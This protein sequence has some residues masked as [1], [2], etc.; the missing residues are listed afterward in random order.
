MLFRNGLFQTYIVDYSITNS[1]NILFTT[2]PT[3]SDEVVLNYSVGNTVPYVYV[4][5]YTNT[6][7]TTST[8]A[9][10]P[11]PACSYTKGV[12]V[13]LNGLLRSANSDYTATSSG[14]NFAFNLS[15]SSVVSCFYTGVNDNEITEQSN[16]PQTVTSGRS[17]YTYF[18]DINHPNSTILSIDGVGQFPINNTYGLTSSSITVNDYRTITPNTFEVNATSLT[19]NTIINIWSK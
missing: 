16:P 18:T 17:I 14:I 9:F 15:I 11:S 13:F 8:V 19:N 12:A 10:D 2:A 1:T 4:Q 7:V 5:S 3:T 6:T